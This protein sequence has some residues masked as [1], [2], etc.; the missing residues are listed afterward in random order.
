MPDGSSNNPYIRTYAK[1]VAALSGKAPPAP[2]SDQTPA[3]DAKP[4]APAPTPTPPASNVNAERDATLARLR[5]RA[6]KNPVKEGEFLP[7][8]LPTPQAK[9]APVGDSEPPPITP[10]SIAVV[11]PPPLPHV[12]PIVPPP[13]VPR[14]P[15]P[16]P[17]V[18]TP[19]PAPVV[20]PI[21]PP[22][23]PSAEV[24]APSPIH[25]YTSDFAEHI[26]RKEASTFSVLAAEADAGKL[27][28]KTLPSTRSRKG[29]AIVAASA[30]LIL[31]GGGGAFAAYRYVASHASVPIAPSVPSLIFADDRI[32]L[33]GEGSQLLQALADATLTPLPDGQVRI[34]YLTQASTTPK[35]TIEVPL[36]GGRLVGA[37]QLSAPDI[38]LRNIAP[39]STVGIVHAGSETRA[40]FILK[41]LSYERTFAGMLQWEGNMENALAVLY[42]TYPAPI[43]EPTIATTT[44]IVKG[45]RVV[46]TTTVA[47]PTPTQV[48]PHFIDEVASNHDVRALK[49][50][51][52]N[53]LLLYGYK[54]KETLIIARNEAAFAELINR[55]GA[56]K[57][58]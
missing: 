31:I 25:T 33:T 24:P 44:T 56:T 1:D 46:A 28:P 4:T 22:P 20:E 7:P 21:P 57:Q 40:F 8:A 39:D 6:L 18:P 32:A 37:L 50:S 35:G 48:P 38:L 29:I 45:K 58:Q 5:E 14:T 10:P 30:V 19:P 55:L 9:A 17:P 49:D 12:A 43:P 23:P 34:V 16:L 42:P 54:D 3:K 51:R 11:T 36:D 15:E 47:A 13:A 2:Q 53:T 41:V 27:A 52:G 26:D